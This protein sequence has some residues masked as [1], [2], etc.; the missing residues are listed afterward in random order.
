M[1]ATETHIY[2]IGGEGQGIEPEISMERYDPAVNL[3]SFVLPMNCG[4]VGA[5]AV[6]L[7]GKIYVMGGNNGY[8]TLRQCEVY[9]VETHQ[10]SMAKGKLD[11]NGFRVK[12]Q[13]F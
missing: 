11:T 9:D 13:P 5:C 2:V 12:T 10:W 6:E 1:V 3:W 7:E 4:K 8:N